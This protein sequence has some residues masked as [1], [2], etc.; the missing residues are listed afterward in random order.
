MTRNVGAQRARI[1]RPRAGETTGSERIERGDPVYD[2]PREEDTEF[3]SAWAKRLERW[4]AEPPRNIWPK[5]ELRP[6]GDAR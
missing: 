1:P 2:P 6:T 5:S 3:R 4:D